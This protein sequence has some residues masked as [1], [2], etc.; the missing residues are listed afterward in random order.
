MVGIREGN[1]RQQPPAELRLPGIAAISSPEN[2]ATRQITV[3]K[4]GSY[5]RGAIPG[6]CEGDA[7]EIQ[8][9]NTF[10]ATAADGWCQAPALWC[11]RSRLLF[12]IF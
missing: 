4:P 6:V 9:G 8:E 12:S 11:S 10:A 7:S 5:H 1:T 3:I 2:S